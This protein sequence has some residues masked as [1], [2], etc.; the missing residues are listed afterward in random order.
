[1]LVACFEDAKHLDAALAEEY[2]PIAEVAV[3]VATFGRGMPSEPAKK[4][5]GTALVAPRPRPSIAD[6][7]T[8]SHEEPQDVRYDFAVTYERDLVIAA[9]HSLVQRISV[10]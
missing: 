7:T 4:V 5:R 3:M 10:A 8:S 1:M 2:A 9:A 6:S